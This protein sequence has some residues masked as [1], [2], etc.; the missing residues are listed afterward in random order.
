MLLENQ[1]ISRSTRNSKKLLSD[2]RYFKGVADTCIAN[3]KRYWIFKF[4]FIH[5]VPHFKMMYKKMYV[6]E[7]VF[8]IKEFDLW[9][10]GHFGA[11]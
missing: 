5:T 4:Y 3:L 2:G 8:E 9:F 11:E 6:H 1:N 10:Q 7:L